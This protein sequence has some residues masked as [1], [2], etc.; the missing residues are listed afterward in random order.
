MS[1]SLVWA[2]SAVQGSVPQSSGAFTAGNSVPRAENPSHRT[3]LCPVA[4]RCS[5]GEFLSYELTVSR[6]DFRWQLSFYL[7]FGSYI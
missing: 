4:L 7:E 3:C 1:M 5:P 2:G 6:M